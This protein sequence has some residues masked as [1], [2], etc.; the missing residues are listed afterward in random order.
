MDFL[1][2]VDERNAA[3][4]ANGGTGVHGIT[5][6]ADRTTDEIS[7]LLKAKSSSSSNHKSKAKKANIYV[8]EEND[9]DDFTV[10]WA[11][12]YT[13]SIKDQGYCGSCWYV[14]T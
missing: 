11:G 8:S 1:V 13:T 14:A 10:N 3:E 7:M 9:D 12:V 4:E 2:I 6:F 5:K